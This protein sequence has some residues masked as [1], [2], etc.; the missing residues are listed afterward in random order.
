M[1]PGGTRPGHPA[2]PALR[3]RGSGPCPPR[4][5]PATAAS[6]GQAAL[7]SACWSEVEQAPHCGIVTTVQDVIQTNP[8]PLNR[9]QTRTNPCAA[10]PPSSAAARRRSSPP[11]R[12]SPSA[13][14]G[15]PGLAALHSAHALPGQ[16][17]WRPWPAR[18]WGAPQ[19]VRSCSSR[20]RAVQG[21][22]RR[23]HDGTSRPTRT[24]TRAGMSCAR[25]PF[26]A[27]RWRLRP[28]RID[29]DLLRHRGPARPARG[30]WCWATRTP[31]PSTRRPG[32]TGTGRRRPD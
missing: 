31:R 27:A 28:R 1:L 12:Q 2:A 13:D 32:S 5:A 21:T 16:A 11:L 17:T 9:N 10:P 3:A 4:P 22:R 25:G 14:P 26:P 23:Y 19:R 20:L 24:R 8:K 29:P 15:H 30:T 6:P 7:A 18:P